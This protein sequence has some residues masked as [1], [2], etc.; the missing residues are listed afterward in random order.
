MSTQHHCSHV[1]RTLVMC[2]TYTYRLRQ[3]CKAQRQRARRRGSSFAIRSMHSARWPAGAGSKRHAEQRKELYA[4][5]SAASQGVQEGVQEAH[6][7]E[8]GGQLGGSEPQQGEG[9]EGELQGQKEV[10]LPQNESSG[11]LGPAAVSMAEAS[12][13]EGVDD[14][15]EGGESPIASVGIMGV[16]QLLLDL[17]LRG[18]AEQV[19]KEK[20]SGTKKQN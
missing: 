19:A 2:G 4:E 17:G 13:G 20:C 14:G 3:A 6:S 9:R 15:A 8:Q 11:R 5:Q 10:S 1:Q 7:R 12:T 18:L 16:W